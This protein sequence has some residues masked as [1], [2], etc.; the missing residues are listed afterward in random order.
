MRLKNE[1][2]QAP[3]FQCSFPLDLLN[4]CNES[5]RTPSGSHKIT[6]L[7]PLLQ[8]QV[9]CVIA[10]NHLR[11]DACLLEGIGAKVGNAI[12]HV[13]HRLDVMLQL[14]QR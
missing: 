9:V 6:E 7:Q 8:L 13:C 11:H 2:R 4:L 5:A 1:G 10:H 3:L 12:E 14:V